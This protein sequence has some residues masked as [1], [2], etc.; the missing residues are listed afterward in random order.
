MLMNSVVIT[1]NELLDELS[2][3]NKAMF[4]LS[5]LNINLLNYDTHPPVNELIDSISSLYF[6]PQIPQD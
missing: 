4:L 3:E 1:L 6:L 5:D 2:K